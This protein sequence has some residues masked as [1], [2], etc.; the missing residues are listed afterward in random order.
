MLTTIIT[1][2]A[3]ACWLYFESICGERDWLEKNK[4]EK[5]RFFQ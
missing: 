4:K 2:T 1:V 3:A 5:I